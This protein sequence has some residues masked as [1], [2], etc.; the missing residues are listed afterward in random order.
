MLPLA[1]NP[2]PLRLLPTCYVY[3]T[4]MYDNNDTFIIHVKQ[5]EIAYIYELIQAVSIPSW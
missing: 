4:S 1:R 2:R 3:I 5:E